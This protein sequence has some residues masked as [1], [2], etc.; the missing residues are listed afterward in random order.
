MLKIVGMSFV[1][2]VKLA[3][4]KGDFA[5]VLIEQVGKIASKPSQGPEDEAKPTDSSYTA[6]RTR[7]SRVSSF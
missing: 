3:W 5:G 4:R 6:I 2:R 1:C 7:R